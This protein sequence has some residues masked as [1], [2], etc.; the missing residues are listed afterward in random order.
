MDPKSCKRECLDLLKGEY[1]M[2]ALSCA[3]E[4]AARV[5]GILCRGSG[6]LRAWG[7]GFRVLV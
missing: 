1:V 4:R 5:R 6:S 3:V 2:A 7:L